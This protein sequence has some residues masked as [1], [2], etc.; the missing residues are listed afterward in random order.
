MR[1]IPA[2]AAALMIAAAPAA[3]AKSFTWSFSSDILTLDPHAS[4][5]TFTNAFLDNVYE[6]LVRHNQRLELEPALA[7]SWDR[8][9]PT[10]WRFQLRENVRFH[11]GE[12]FGA[13]E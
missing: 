4:N 2:A 9:S 6:T 8:A 1:L 10:V 13:E 12:T 7:T 5:N 11:N 3:L